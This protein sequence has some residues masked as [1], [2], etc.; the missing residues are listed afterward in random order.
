MPKLNAA[1]ARAAKKAA[2]D[3]GPS[4]KLIP[5]GYIRL[6]LKKVTSKPSRAGD[7]MWTWDFVAVAPKGV[8]GET[9][10]WT[11]LTDDALWKLGQIFDAFDVEPDTDTDE[12]IGDTL[13]AEIDHEVQQE[14]KGKG[15]KRA[16]I[17][18]FLDSSE[19]PKLF[20]GSEDAD[21]A[22]DRIA[23][24][25]ED[26]ADDHEGSDDDPPF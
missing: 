7:P 6:K 4:G 9:R 2:A 16:V 19:K 11:V 26:G 14:G 25:D 1:K 8:E 15:K 12:L 18:Q 3:G 10:E 21:G 24:S 20:E 22:T 17:V 23:D 5:R 13:M